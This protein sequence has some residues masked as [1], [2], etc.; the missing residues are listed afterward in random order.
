MT[1]PRT[2]QPSKDAL[3]DRVILITGASDGIGKA[4]AIAA[5]SHGAQVVLHGRSVRKLEAV[6]DEIVKAR[7]NTKNW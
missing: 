2:Y 5:A 4:V 3:K 1:D 7:T 6:Y